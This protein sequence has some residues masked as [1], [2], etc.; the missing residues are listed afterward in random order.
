MKDKITE[1]VA[2]QYIESNNPTYRHWKKVENIKLSYEEMENSWKKNIRIK[3]P[4][5]NCE[6][7]EFYSTE[8]AGNYFGLSGERIRQKIVSTNYP[9]YFYIY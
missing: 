4:T 2:R 6:G 1:N 7:I 3:L 5:I 9:E 8:E